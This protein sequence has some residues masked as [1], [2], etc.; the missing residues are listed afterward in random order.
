MTY[1]K[2]FLG[3]SMQAL[4]GQQL[5]EWYAGPVPVKSTKSMGTEQIAG[6]ADAAGYLAREGSS[7]LYAAEPEET[8]LRAR[9]VPVE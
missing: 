6:G 9:T 3:Q 8:W 5:R 7:S 4:W 2:G 1:S